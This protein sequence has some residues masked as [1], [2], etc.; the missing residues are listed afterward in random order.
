M[1]ESNQSKNINILVSVLRNHQAELEEST[2]ITYAILEQIF[3]ILDEKMIYV[4]QIK[5]F[6]VLLLL[7]KRLK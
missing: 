1:A 6:H 5:S 7:Q 3:E 2:N 4:K